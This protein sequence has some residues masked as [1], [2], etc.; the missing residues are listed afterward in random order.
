MNAYIKKIESLIEQAE[1]KR[2]Q[3]V[4]KDYPGKWHAPEGLFKTSNAQTIADTLSQNGDASY[5]QA[6]GRITFYIN[7][8]GKNLSR[9][10]LETM[11]KVKV[12]IRSR[13]NK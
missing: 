12:L 6:M 7:R 2:T 5:K 1:I 3:F 10:R 8:A 11:Q 4:T 9:E 13:Y